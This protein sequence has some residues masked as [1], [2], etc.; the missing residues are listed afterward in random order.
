VALDRRGVGDSRKVPQREL[1]WSI[2]AAEGL[3]AGVRILEYSFLAEYEVAQRML[4]RSRV[5]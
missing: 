1:K 3:W 4:A 2:A 5:G